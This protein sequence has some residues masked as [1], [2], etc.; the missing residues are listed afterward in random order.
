MELILFS[1]LHSQLAH[2]HLIQTHTQTQGNVHILK[3]THHSLGIAF[4]FDDG[5]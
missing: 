5:F 4:E 2:I 3:H 1:Q